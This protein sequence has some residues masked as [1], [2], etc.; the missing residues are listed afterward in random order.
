MQLWQK[1]IA[2]HIHVL[3]AGK[4]TS[5]SDFFPRL[6]L[7]GPWASCIKCLS[8]AFIYLRIFLE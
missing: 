2:M 1:C 4:L 7:P 3:G 6:L 5:N 8:N